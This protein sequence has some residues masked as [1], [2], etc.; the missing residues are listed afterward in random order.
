FLAP[1]I[2]RHDPRQM[3]TFYYMARPSQDAHTAQYRRIADHWRDV[4]HTP[5]DDV[6]CRMITDDRIDIL[7]DLSG[8]FDYNRL[9]VF[10]RRPAPVQFTFPN[11]PGTTGVDGIDYFFTD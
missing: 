3:E 6:V 1:W 5:D 2:Y 9:G 7:V 10:A 4:S 11:Y 8:H